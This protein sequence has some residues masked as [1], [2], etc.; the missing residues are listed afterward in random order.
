[1]AGTETGGVGSVMEKP[2]QTQRALLVDAKYASPYPQAFHRFWPRHAI[3]AGLV[4]VVFVTALVLLAQHYPVPTDPNMPP[5]P[6]EGATIPAPEWYLFLLFQPFWYLTGD[7]VWLRPVGTFWLPLLF[8]VGLLAIPFLFGRQRASGARSKLL[9]RLLIG[10]VGWVVWSAGM[11]AVGGSGYPAKTT[12][13]TSCHNPMMGVRQA[14]PPANMGKFYR[15]A[16]Q[17]QIDVGKY[18]I[19]DTMGMGDSYKDANWQLRHFYEPTMTW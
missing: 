2:E 10:L 6:D 19:G 4:V 14:L 1:M 16:R 18:R 17:Q 12:G 3:K 7:Q 11:A 8:V 15:E 13:C 9:K 5:M